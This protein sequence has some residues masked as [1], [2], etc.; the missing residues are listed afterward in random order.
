M[1]I[2]FKD[3]AF[4]DH[5]K[6]NLINNED[7]TISL[8]DVTDYSQI[9][10]VINAEKFKE[11]MA[12]LDPLGIPKPFFGTIAPDG[13]ALSGA[14]LLKSENPALY[15]IFGDKYGSSEY[16]FSL[17]DLK[18]RVLVGRADVFDGSYSFANVGNF[19]G[20]ITHS[21]TASECVLREHNHLISH[22]H[23]ISVYPSGEHSHTLQG[24]RKVLSDIGGNQV[25]SYERIGTDANCT[26]TPVLSAGNHNHSASVDT[27]GGSS[28]YASA[29]NVNPHNNLQPYMV[30]NYIFRKG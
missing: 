1:Y 18:G 23:G 2:D 4:E 11:L 30:I 13:Y 19:G 16:Y 3:A 26:V 6:F 29:S 12:Y 14:S 9:G 17:P 5:R 20:N 25:L 10:T 15:T 8:Q 24:W 7:N 27:F 21:L 22:S 28:G